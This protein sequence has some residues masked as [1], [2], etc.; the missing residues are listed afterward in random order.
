MAQLPPNGY[1]NPS[2]QFSNPFTFADVQ[3]AFQQGWQQKDAE[4]T[5]PTQEAERQLHLEHAKALLAQDKADQQYKK[6]QHSFDLHKMFVEASK[7]PQPLQDAP[8]PQ[9]SGPE[10]P[11]QAGSLAELSRAL[12]NP[13]NAPQHATMQVPGIEADPTNPYLQQGIPSYQAQIPTQEEADQRAVDQAQALNQAKKPTVH[14][15]K[16][17]IPGLPEGDYSASDI[18]RAAAGGYKTDVLAQIAREK[19][20]MSKGKL[21]QQEQTIMDTIDS[22]TPMLHTLLHQIAPAIDTTQ[23]FSDDKNLRASLD[24][25]KTNSNQALGSGFLGDAASSIVNR[26]EAAKG[27]M[28]LGYDAPWDQLNDQIAHL[29]VLSTS[30][31]MRNSRNYNLMKDV[32]KFMPDPK[33]SDTLNAQNT[34][35]LLNTFAKIKKNTGQTTS[36]VPGA[37]PLTAEE[38]FAGLPDK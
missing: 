20:A 38:F 3:K 13:A 33:A 16:G 25:I 34:V 36:P 7:Q 29:R 4:L 9:P 37:G 32:Y 5:E 30:P 1:N 31:Y 18:A 10:I 17:D 28:G 35:N 22:A 24:T 21:T 23:D 12:M 14:V 19:A 8:P 11:G 2:G 27:G 6:A 15:N 26:A